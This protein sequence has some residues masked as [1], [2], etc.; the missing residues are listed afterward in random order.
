MGWRAV[1]RAIDL[2][3]RA[4][5]VPG[6]VVEHV[7]APTA[8]QGRYGGSSGLARDTR[9]RAPAP[10]HPLRR[11][12]SATPPY[13]PLGVQN[14]GGSALQPPAPALLRRVGA[15]GPGLCRAVRSAGSPIG[16]AA[17]P[18]TA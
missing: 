9:S 4:P 14:R 13:S 18:S 17:A 6:A 10:A 3:A 16:T 15:S 12:G 2:A 7:F 1:A 5:L 11:P 8:A